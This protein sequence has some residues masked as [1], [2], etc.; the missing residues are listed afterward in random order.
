MALKWLCVECEETFGEETAAYGSICVPLC[1]PCYEAREK[2]RRQRLRAD[3]A[4]A[5]RG[6]GEE[7]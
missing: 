4:P 6:V 2:R 3:R 7:G 1:L 5:R